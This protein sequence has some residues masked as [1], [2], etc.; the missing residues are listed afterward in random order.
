VPAASHPAL[1]R[2]Q[3]IQTLQSE[4]VFLARSQGGKLVVIEVL[5]D[6]ALPKEIGDAVAHEASLVAKLSHEAVVQMRAIIQ[7]AGLTAIV[8]DFVHG[9]S[10]QRLLR[11]TTA[12]GVRL[13]HEAAM[14]ILERVLSGLAYA[15]AQS[16]PIVHGSVSAQSVIVG[17]D[18]SALLGGFR[19]TQMRTIINPAHPVDAVPVSP[20]QARGAAPTVKSDLFCAALVAMRLAT[21]R[22]PYG[23]SPPSSK[24]RIEAMTE[25]RLPSLSKMRPDLSLP[26]RGSLELALEVDPEKRAITAQELLDVVRGSFDPSHGRE[27]LAKVLARWR[28]E[29]DRSVTPWEK[30]ASIPDEVPRIDPGVPDGALA[31]AMP[32]DRP[33]GEGLPVAGLAS[34][35]PSSGA[36]PPTEATESVSRLGAVATDAL[37]MPP[38]PPMRITMPSV[39][40]YGGPPVNIPQAPV[41]EPIPGSTWAA[42]TAGVVVLMIIFALLMFWWLSGPTP[43]PPAPH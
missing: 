9:V 10:L 18:G 8:H 12:R 38:L 42:I 28:G 5:A 21:G 40:V 35:V 16:S 41:K 24:Q 27:S 33:S 31:L 29:L 4:S 3:V 30:R 17:W 23:G 13:P 1:A 34:D 19:M 2:F 26:L 11:F 14:Y 39:P 36:L 25:G 43:P 37:E 20:E 6:K 22:T 15:H 7:D 32:D